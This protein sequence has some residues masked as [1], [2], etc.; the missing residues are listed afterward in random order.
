[1]TKKR[2]LEILAWENRFFCEIP[3]RNRKFSKIS[4]EN[5][6]FFTWI[7]DPQI[8]NQVDA[9]DGRD[10]SESCKNKTVRLQLSRSWWQYKTPIAARSYFMWSYQVNLNMSLTWNSIQLPTRESSLWCKGNL[11]WEQWRNSGRSSLWLVL[12]AHF[13]LGWPSLC[14][15]Y[16]HLPNTSHPLQKTK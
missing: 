6:Y 11:D 13:R 16:A 1:M 12:L 10:A 15:R 4:L 5:R 14:D 2:S 9:A 7:H 3:H 8:S